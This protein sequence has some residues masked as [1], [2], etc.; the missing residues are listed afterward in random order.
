MAWGGGWGGGGGGM[1]A[2]SSNTGL[3][4]GGIPSELMDGATKILATE[5]T[6][7]P[8]HLE[9][10]Q[11]PSAKERQRLTLPRMLREYPAFVALGS[12]LVV[13]ISLVMQAGP[14]LTEYAINNGMSPGHHSLRVIAVCGA[15]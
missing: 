4:F 10:H 6:H 14:L 15:I 8:S 2:S 13:V 11:R 1:F 5:P 7:E 3:P 12:F 9:F